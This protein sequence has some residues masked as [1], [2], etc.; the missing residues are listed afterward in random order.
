MIK[1]KR[2]PDANIKKVNCLFDKSYSTV[3]FNGCED[4]ERKPCIINFAIYNNRTLF[5]VTLCVKQDL[6][7]T[8]IETYGTGP[9]GSAT[10][11]VNSF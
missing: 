9:S 10:L 3:F 1:K 11:D 2:Q 6:F 7:A 5:Y 4:A 8:G